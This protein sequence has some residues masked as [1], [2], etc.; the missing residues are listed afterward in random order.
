MYNYLKKGSTIGIIAPS[1]GLFDE[2]HLNKYLMA[3]KFFLNEGYK[4]VEAKSIYNENFLNDSKPSVR[5][6]EFMDM[7]LDNNIDLI[8]SVCGGELLMEVLEYIDFSLIKKANP[9]YIL[10]YSDNTNLTF[11]LKTLCNIDSIYGINATAF[12]KMNLEYVKDTYEL[13]CGK[14][15][16]F[17]SYDY[18]EDEFEEFNK[19]VKYIGSVDIKGML[20][21]GCLE[22]LKN[23]CGTKY[24]NV[25]DFSKSN[26]DLIYYFDACEF[27]PLQVYQTLWQLKNAGWFN[28]VIGFVFGRTKNNMDYLSYESAIYRALGDI[29]K[30]IV[31]NADLGHI[32]PIV[33]F[34]N[35]RI[36]HIKV[37]DGKGEFIYE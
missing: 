32:H 2:E 27:S 20:I 36:C 7:Y 25:C 23:L 16:S 17:K 6:K 12:S 21:G 11:L 26:K 9:K 15:F 18:Y 22:V 10:G 24:D 8:I 31:I 37:Q 4:I 3:K 34:I 35:G 28:N 5:A 14:K 1:F 33:P 19:E 29:T 30:N 13:L